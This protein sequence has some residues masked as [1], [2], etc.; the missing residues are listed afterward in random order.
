MWFIP[1]GIK[2]TQYLIK[3]RNL[4]FPEEFLKILLIGLSLSS[5]LLKF[6]CYEEVLTSGTYM[7]SS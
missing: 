1:D 5:C 2:C 6:S 7:S 4:K 3:Q